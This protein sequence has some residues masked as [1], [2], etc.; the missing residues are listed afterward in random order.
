MTYCQQ[1][2]MCC[3]L[4]WTHKY[5]DSV[6]CAHIGNMKW[7]C[8][9][10]TYVNKNGPVVNKRNMFCTYYQQK[11][12]LVYILSTQGTFCAYTKRCDNNVFCMYM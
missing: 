7:I 4:T 1:K 9:L 8:L 2:Y 10:Y 5:A 6:C 12:H 3:K 11:V